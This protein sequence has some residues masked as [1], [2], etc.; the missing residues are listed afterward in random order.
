MKN[1]ELNEQLSAVVDD[2]LRKEEALFLSRRLGR[3]PE[4]VERL[5]RYFLISDA[6][7]RQLPD[8][9]D[10]GFAAR[11]SAAID[12][13]PAHSLQASL[14]KRIAAPLTGLGIA[15]SVAMVAVG[16]W[17]PEQV[18]P[19]DSQP[20]VTAGG[21]AGSATPVAASQSSEWERL[22]PEVRK[23]LNGYFVNHSEHSSTGQF[24][25]VLNYVRIAGQQDRE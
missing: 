1:D 9:V 5:E 14:A 13:E 3:A 7:R 11:V 6:L 25:G 21:P 20:V 2:E 17:A 15:A 8:S 24:G 16:L 22:D 18:G 10:L 12:A 4:A 23:R 19:L